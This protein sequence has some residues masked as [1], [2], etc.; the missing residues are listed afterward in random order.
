MN[1]VKKKIIKITEKALRTYKYADH[2][3]LISFCVGVEYLC[4]VDEEATADFSEIIAIV[5]KDWLFDYMSNNLGIRNPRKF[6]QEEY[7]FDDSIIW[8][9][10]AIK[11][12]HLM[13]I[14]F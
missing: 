5:D 4:D 6:L 8:F 7:T 2:R 10:K 13:A 14:V 1:S 9:K 12:N 3:D 11:E